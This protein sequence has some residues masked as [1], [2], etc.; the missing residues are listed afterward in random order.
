MAIGDRI[1]ERRKQLGLTQTELAE[2]L[3]LTSK[4]AISTVENNKE[5]MTI[6]RV[7]K[8]AEALDTTT[9]YLM[10]HISRPDRHK[11]PHRIIDVTPTINIIQKSF[12]EAI[13]RGELEAPYYDDET[14]EM[15]QELFDNKDLRLLFDAAKDCRPED[16]QMAADLLKRLKQTNPDG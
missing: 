4:A 13:E 14:A 11:G 2:R 16:L 8:Y 5:K 12:E 10:G 9:A 6:D 15:A 7:E 1:K 3:G